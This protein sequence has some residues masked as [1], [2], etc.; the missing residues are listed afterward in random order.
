MYVTNI[1]IWKQ[2][3]VLRKLYFESVTGGCVFI[4]ANW[5]AEPYTSDSDTKEIASA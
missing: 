2:L 4:I 5:T 1:F 3:I